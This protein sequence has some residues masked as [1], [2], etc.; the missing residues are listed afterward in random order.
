VKEAYGVGMEA[1]V[2]KSVA[3]MEEFSQ[4]SEE[5]ERK[6]MWELEEE[7]RK[8][9]KQLRKERGIVI[10]DWLTGGSRI[11]TPIQPSIRAG[12]QWCN[13]DERWEAANKK[14][15]VNSKGDPG[16]QM[17]TTKGV[18][19][20][21]ASSSGGTPMCQHGNTSTRQHVKAPTRQHGNASTR[22]RRRRLGRGPRAI[23]DL[24]VRGRH[25]KRTYVSRC[26]GRRL[27][28]TRLEILETLVVIRFFRY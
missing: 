14:E 17:T 3:L 22:G 4:R 20:A 11:P 16:A 19:I 5:R 25:V 1:Q 10:K 15:A 8:N 2:R 26:Q 21:S 12:T 13:W 18:A 27:S 9:Q 7:K 6:L 23:G 28:R 24:G